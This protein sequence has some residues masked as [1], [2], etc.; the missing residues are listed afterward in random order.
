M[1][2][3]LPQVASAAW[4]NP[5]SWKIF[6]RIFA[7]KIEVYKAENTADIT[8]PSGVSTTTDS[9]DEGEVANDDKTEKKAESSSVIQVA[10]KESI[11]QPTTKTDT[12]K[13]QVLSTN[14]QTISTTTSENEKT[15]MDLLKQQNEILK[16]Q[17]EA[18]QQIAKNTAIVNGSCATTLNICTTGTLSDRADTSTHYLWS[19]LGNNGGT[20][21]SCSLPIPT[22][23]PTPA[24]IPA[25]VTQ[26]VFSYPNREVSLELGPFYSDVFTMKILNTNLNQ[27][28]IPV[29]LIL[30]PNLS[31]SSSD[32]TAEELDFIFLK[33]SPQDSGVRLEQGGEYGFWAI[34]SGSQKNFEVII[35][36]LESIK[37]KHAGT[38]SISIGDIGLEWLN[39]PNNLGVPVAMIKNLSSDV[40]D[41]RLAS[42]PINMTIRI[43]DTGHI[44]RCVSKNPSQPADESCS[45]WKL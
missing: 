17:L 45:D 20:N 30:K 39:N 25:P 15:E 35:G 28:K 6:E 22:S 2:L 8:T 44:L 18:Q 11:T 41:K 33:L 43:D 24:P 14:K 31:V 32:Y 40:V 36:N 29:R 9:Q 3:I 19:C 34:D 37:F 27:I 5:F 23:T 26:D 1:A 12:Q 16:G 13:T 7:P 10:K 4:W 21:A 38:I 42:H